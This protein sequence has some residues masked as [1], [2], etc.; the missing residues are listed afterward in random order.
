MTKPFKVR[1]C[2]RFAPNA[3]GRDLVVGDL[4]GH[5]DLLELAL[6]EI[7]FDPRSDRVLSVGD[8]I[9]RGPQSLATLALLEEPWFHAVLGNHEL[10]LLNCL[11]Y[12]GSRLY[13]RKSFACGGGDWI[14]AAIAEHPKL[15]ARLAD[16]VAALPLAIYMARGPDHASFNVVHGDLHPIG[17]RQQA[18]F[19]KPAIGVHEAEAAA[20]SRVHF[21]AAVKQ[22]L[23]GLAF[24]RHFVRVSAAPLGPLPI[25]YAGHSPV[26][27]IVVHDSHVYIDRRSARQN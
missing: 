26:E 11:G 9:D 14:V 24:E 15:V 8:H 19:G 12:Y 16:R 1:R 27:Q 4:H 22:P 20:S 6:D 2:L 17:S 5:R 10:M 3:K 7:G 23:V 25:T 13:P 18:L 21:S